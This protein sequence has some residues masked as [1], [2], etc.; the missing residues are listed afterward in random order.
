MRLY[1]HPASTTSRIVQL[2]ALDQGVSLE[3][4]MVDLMSGEH[5]QPEF[6]RINPNSFVPV[7]EDGD[8]R[9]TESSAIVKYLADKA[10]SFAAATPPICTSS[11]G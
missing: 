2:F 10:G 6:A 1:Y 9:L 4:Q 11:T 7:L 3:Y 5:L 8:S